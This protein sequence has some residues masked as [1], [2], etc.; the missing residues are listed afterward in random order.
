MSSN[1]QVQ[2]QAP[3][4]SGTLDS[5]ALVTLLGR[6]IE[7]RTVSHLIV[8]DGLSERCVF[9]PV[10]G[11]RLSSVGQRRGRTP[12]DALLARRDVKGEI[13]RT[14]EG[15]QAKV[16]AVVEAARA[17]HAS[18]LDDEPD[19]DDEL[20]TENEVEDAV[21]RLGLRQQWLDA[22]RAS[23]RDEL[24]DLAAWD[25]AR[26]EFREANPPAKLFRPELEAVKV[27]LGVK[28]LLAEVRTACG[29]WQRM[30]PKLGVPSR[31]R[32]YCDHPE[33]VHSVAG[34]AGPMLEALPRQGARLSDL[35]VAAR[36]KG[37]DVV[38]AGQALIALDDR[39]VIRIDTVPPPVGGEEKKQRALSDIDRIEA[40]IALMV[41]ELQAR[42]RL[43]TACKEVGDVPRAV[44]NLRLVEDALVAEG[45]TEEA[46]GVLREVLEIAPQALDARERVAGL[47]EQVG[48][49]PEA[50]AEW[51]GLARQLSALNLFN[52]A[53]KSLRRAIGLDPRNADHRRRLVALLE[54]R[55]EREEAAQELERVAA[56]FEEAGQ[57]EAALACW[58]DL[59]R[60]SPEHP[61]ARARL[62]AARL[63]SAARL[64]AMIAIPALALLLLIAGGWVWRRHQALEAWDRSREVALGMAR[65][66]RW[67]DA[68]RELQLVALEHGLEPERVAPVLALIDHLEEDV[69]REELAAAQALEREGKVPE[70]RDRHAAVEKDHPGRPSAAR[71]AER[72]RAIAALEEEAAGIALRV[73]ELLAA[74]KPAEALPAARDLAARLPWTEAAGRTVFP[75]EVRTSPAGAALTVDDESWAGRTPT[76]VARPVARPIR[77]GVLLEGHLPWSGTLD[78]RQPGFRSPVE[79]GLTRAPRWRLETLGPLAAEPA[80]MVDGG[81]VVGGEDPL[82]YALEPDGQVRWRVPLAPFAALAGRPVATPRIV[83]VAETGGRVRG[84]DRRSGTVAWTREL[85]DAPSA[86]GPAEGG[87]VVLSTPE[88]LFA[89]DGE[90]GADVWSLDLRARL[91]APARL[92]SHQR[93]L[94][95]TDDGRVQFIDAA[96]GKLETRL[97]AGGRPSAPAVLAGAA[98]CL[99][100]TE[101]GELKAVWR[102]VTWTRKLPAPAVHPPA[103]TD[104]AIYVAAGTHLLRLDLRDGEVVW[105]LDLGTPLGAP[106][107]TVGR[108]YVGGADGVLRALVARN[109]ELRWSLQ[110]QGEVIAAPIIHRGTVFAVS[111][112][113]ELLAIAE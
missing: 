28:D 86:V 68:R 39:G 50:V 79:V 6:A 60:L 10:G 32:I 83:A 72:L 5:R 31:T 42:R 43:A 102:G 27:S 81:L 37:Y 54:A 105:D 108:V 47:L 52:R 99:V 89:L 96:T 41:Q 56:L 34:A 92:V 35:L 15:L 20:L 76:T 55:G 4:L 77:L 12:L 64:P 38:A 14:L 67:R 24:L 63:P 45:R 7:T 21:D 94:A 62:D 36:R 26:Y 70:A 74:G 84:I 97:P 48:R 85:P 29:E 98:S 8:S 17:R 46:I 100:A 25:E 103:P 106:T 71:A 93:I 95:A 111:T 1:E 91:A 9:F 22:V 80:L 40:A 113:Q 3:L 82:V 30:A 13:R 104:D 90:S 18:G 49:V 33:R 110:L 75:I 23:A 51:L 19:D 66:A 57:T 61:T 78:L 101:D 73:E 87:L 65:E 107:A 58:A 2:A 88:R 109:G 69:A 59:L 11:L 53:L 16:R 112:G 44:Q